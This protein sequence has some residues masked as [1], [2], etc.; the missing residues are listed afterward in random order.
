MANLRENKQESIMS[1]I[2]DMLALLTS[3]LDQFLSR[4][5]RTDSEFKVIDPSLWLDN[6]VWK[7]IGGEIEKKK[8]KF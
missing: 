3:T 2:L 4:F 5:E 6:K 8:H 7:C 1:W